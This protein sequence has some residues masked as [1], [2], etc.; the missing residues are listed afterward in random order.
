MLL[1]NLSTVIYCVL[2]RK[3]TKRLHINKN[4]KIATK[5]IALNKITDLLK[6]IYIYKH[7]YCINESGI[8]KAKGKQALEY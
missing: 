6:K 8:S 5:Y 2:I 7:L 4:R 1:H 3:Q